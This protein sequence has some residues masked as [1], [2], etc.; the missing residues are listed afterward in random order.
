MAHSES[1]SQGKA[2]V[3]FGQSIVNDTFCLTEATRMSK[4]TRMLAY[5]AEQLHAKFP[6]CTLHIPKDPVSERS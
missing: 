2:R 1:S 5:C 3:T 4:E 6:T